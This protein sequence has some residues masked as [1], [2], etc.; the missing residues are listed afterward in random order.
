MA[1]KMNR[2]IIKGS[3]LHKNSQNIRVNPNDLRKPLDTPFRQDDKLLTNHKDQYDLYRLDN[4]IDMSNR[5]LESLKEDYPDRVDD[6][7]STEADLADSLEKRKKYTDKPYERKDFGE[8]EVPAY[9]YTNDVSFNRRGEG[10]TEEELENRR[11]YNWY[12]QN[13]NKLN[14]GY[15]NLE[16]FRADYPE[17][18]EY[19]H[20]QTGQ[21]VWGLDG[22]GWAGHN[23]QFAVPEKATKLSPRPIEQIPTPEMEGPK[24]LPPYELVKNN[25]E[26]FTIEKQGTAT[27]TYPKGE[28]GKVLI[29]LKD[30]PGRTVW[31]GSQTEFQEKYGEFLKPGLNSWNKYKY[32]LPENL[33]TEIIPGV[34]PVEE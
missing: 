32:Y 5:F 8:R 18:S 24:K 28:D 30:K 17:A 33:P 15:K 9:N 12:D 34:G 10:L 2:P 21:T 19:K 13:K 1:F 25:T 26:Y 29:R 22:E 20:Y 7:K 11:S 27:H 4:K 23:I 3:A 6:I 31:S 16:D 14:F